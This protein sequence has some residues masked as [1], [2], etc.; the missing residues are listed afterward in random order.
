MN[1]IF[2]IILLMLAIGVLIIAWVAYYLYPQEAKVIGLLKNGVLA[3]VEDANEIVYV[4]D[5]PDGTKPK[6]GEIIIVRHPLLHNLKH[7]KDKLPTREGI[8][9][10]KAFWIEDKKAKSDVGNVATLMYSLPHSKWMA[11]CHNE[12][13][14]LSFDKEDCK[15][16][17]VV[18]YIPK[19][20]VLRRF[21]YV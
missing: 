11:Q 1:N 12:N 2:L 6:L 20:W 4:E 17:D 15:E 18:L 9:S 3:Y 7:E 8:D 14:V 16:G 13:I 21:Y 10:G 19:T 5:L